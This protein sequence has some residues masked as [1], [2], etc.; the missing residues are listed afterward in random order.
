MTT[1]TF[2][3]TVR[4]YELSHV[5]SLAHAA[6]LAYKDHDAVERTAREWGFQRVR[7]FRVA[8]SPPFPLEDTQAYVMA[9]DHMIVIAFRGTEPAQIRDWLSDI[10]TPPVPERSCEGRVHW[11]F[12]RALDA[13]YTDLSTALREFRDAEQTVWVTGHSLGGALAMLAAARL[14]FVD[15]VLADGVYTFG[16]P[17][18]CDATL[19]KAYEEVFRGRMYR[20]VNNNDVI[21]HVPPEPIFR[22]VSEVR[23]IDAAGRI[24][25]KPMSVLG[26]LADSVRGHTADPFSL[27]VDALRDHAMNAYVTHLDAAAR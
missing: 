7:S 18:T 20:F 2:D 8:F 16:Q 25:E 3:H 14:H 19:A 1:I 6:R 10:N 15:G 4:D 23:H 13:V 5:R 26:G 9:G 11:G 27:G 17:R 22:H 21:A 24:H 12:Q